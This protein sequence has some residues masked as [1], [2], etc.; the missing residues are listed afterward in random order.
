MVEIS[1]GSDPLTCTRSHTNPK[2]SSL[3]SKLD[4]TLSFPSK[5]ASPSPS[6]SYSSRKT[7]SRH[8]RRSMLSE[9][10]TLEDFQSQSSVNEVGE[11]RILSAVG[12]TLA[13]P[14]EEVSLALST[15]SQRPGNEEVIADSS[16]TQFTAMTDVRVSHRERPGFPRTS[17]SGT[18]IFT[19]EA[20]GMELDGL[21]VGPDRSHWT[22][23]GGRKERTYL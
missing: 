1:I 5:S 20:D 6:Y 14:R 16:F 3:H 12:S 22:R 9:V 18:Q 8:R 7:A 19:P 13:S 4:S 10:C 21:P 2:N 15:Q 17:T 11:R 23:K